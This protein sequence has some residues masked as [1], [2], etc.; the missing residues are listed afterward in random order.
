MAV[1]RV[2]AWRASRI[3]T[4]T[5]AAIVFSALG[6]QLFLSHTPPRSDADEAPLRGPNERTVPQVAQQADDR[7][8]LPQAAQSNGAAAKEASDGGVVGGAAEPADFSESAKPSMEAALAKTEHE[9]DAESTDPLWSQSTE[10]RIL[11]EIA[12]ITGLE[13]LTVQVQCRTTMCRIELAE[14][15]QLEPGSV[16][17]ANATFGQLVLGLDQKPLWIMTTVDRYG[18]PNSLAYVVRNHLDAT[19]GRTQ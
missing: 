14:R 3:A 1:H 16:L 15:R 13:A 5:I 4:L 9:F 19:D 6:A 2:R 8:Q 11:G 17:P 18:T 7:P 12:Q 10:T